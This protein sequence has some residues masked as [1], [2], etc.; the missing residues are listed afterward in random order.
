[1]SE[2]K[3]Q[4]KVVGGKGIGQEDGLNPEVILFFKM[5]YSLNNVI[6]VGTGKGYYD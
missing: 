4:L 2:G 3:P 6:E 1:M 5:W